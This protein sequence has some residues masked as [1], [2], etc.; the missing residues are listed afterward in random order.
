MIEDAALFE[1][2]Q[3]WKEFQPE[4]KNLFPTESALRWFIRQ[5][6]QALVDLD[7]LLKLPRGNYI[8][9]EPFRAAAINL[10]RRSSHETVG[11]NRQPS[12]DLDS[13]ACPK[14]R[15]GELP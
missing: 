5:H 9:P 1:R 4:A 12:G 10:M 15:S 8:D 7:V 3:Y 2:V 14:L 11:V 13:R 6:E